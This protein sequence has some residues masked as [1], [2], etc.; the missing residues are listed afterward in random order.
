MRAPERSYSLWTGLIESGR[1]VR[2]GPE[3]ILAVATWDPKRRAYL[4]TST[5]SPASALQPSSLDYSTVAGPEERHRLAGPTAAGPK[6]SRAKLLDRL[7]LA[8][9]VF[10]ARHGLSRCSSVPPQ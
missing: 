5:G 8:R 7:L 1:H 3:E 6:G 10:T 9:R 2:A 4:A